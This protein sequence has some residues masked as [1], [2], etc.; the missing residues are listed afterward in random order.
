M[1]RVLIADPKKSFWAESSELND[2]AIGSTGGTWTFVPRRVAFL[3][4]FG[5]FCH[6]TSSKGN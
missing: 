6:N 2:F 3:R 1:L 5:L 4:S